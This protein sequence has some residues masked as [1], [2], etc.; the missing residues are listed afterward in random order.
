ML[1]QYQSRVEY[2]NL[3]SQELHSLVPIKCLN[4]NAMC[5]H[6]CPSGIFGDIDS[7]HNGLPLILV[8]NQD[9]ILVLWHCGDNDTLS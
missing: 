8:F 3:R 2:L 7:V 4:V 1:C 9:I 6:A 5:N